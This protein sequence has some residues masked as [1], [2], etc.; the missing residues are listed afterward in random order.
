[1]MAGDF[2][3]FLI[4]EWHQSIEGG[5]VASPPPHEQFGNSFGI[6][7]IHNQLRP[8]RVR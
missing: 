4:Y 3:E 8:E 2:A 1:M 7:L 5:L 6:L